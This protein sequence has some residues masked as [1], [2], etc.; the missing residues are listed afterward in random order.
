MF[1]KSRRKPQDTQD[2]A[3]ALPA[4]HPLNPDLNQPSAIPTGNTHA[5]GAMAPAANAPT[6]AAG[7][8]LANFETLG[9][10]LV[11]T[12]IADVISGG[13]AREL[14]D[15]IAS[16]SAYAAD[17]PNTRP[18][19]DGDL[20]GHGA[21]PRHFVLDLQNVE[22]MDSACLGA[23]VELLTSMQSRGGRIA[24]VNAGRNVEYLF[25]LTQLDRLFPICR[26]VMT[27]IEAVE[28][29]QGGLPAGKGKKKRA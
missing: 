1:G 12:V 15:E 22:Y 13:D 29:G 19:M 14:V 2:Q 11:V 5:P 10:T 18:S 4:I 7:R 28:R 21:A 6:V 16:R 3:P 9:Q 8:K 26:E 20:T 23:L 24:L 17:R 27:A 25:R